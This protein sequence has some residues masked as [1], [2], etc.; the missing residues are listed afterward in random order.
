RARRN[1]EMARKLRESGVEIS[2]EE[3]RNAFDTNELGR[4][5]FAALLVQKGY[6]KTRQLAFDRYFAKGRP[7]FVDKAGADLSA[8]VAAIRDSG[9]IPVQAHPLSM[10]VSWGK[11]PDKIAEVQ[12]AGVMGLEA[13]HPGARISEAER[14]EELAHSRGMLVTGGSDFHGEKVRSDRRL[15]FSSGGLKLK[16]SFFF[17]ELLPRVK[18]IRGSEDLSFRL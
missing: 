4:P 7:C 2:I 17:D 6:V 9:G 12:A 14:L 13:W 8:A 16:D 11:I 18:E 10:F 5:H 3:L 1:E 15:G